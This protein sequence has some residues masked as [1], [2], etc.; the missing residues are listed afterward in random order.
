MRPVNGFGPDFLR[1][2]V[3][4]SIPSPQAAALSYRASFIAICL[5]LTLPMA[6]FGHAVL[7]AFF[8]LAALASALDLRYAETRAQFGAVLRSWTGRA[9]LA[10]F[11]W[12]V[13]ATL[14]SSYP[15]RSAEVAVRV[16]CFIGLTIPIVLHLAK[17]RAARELA[18]RVCA[19]GFA[20]VCVLAVA[21]FL[22]DTDLLILFR[23]FTHKV[24]HA[25]N[26]LKPFQSLIVVAV[27]VLAWI[28]L[29]HARLTRIAA[30]LG[31]LFGLV[32]T[33]GITGQSSR[34]AMAGIAGGA[35]TLLAIYLL[36]RLRKPIRVAVIAG[37]I[38]LGV[39]GMGVVVSVLPPPPVTEQDRTADPVPFLDFHREAIWGF[40]WHKA[41][42]KPVFGYGINTIDRSPG[43]QQEVLDLNQ[44]YVPS[45]PHN[46]LLEI[47]SETG[48]PGLVLALM[49]I[50]SALIPLSRWAR[51]KDRDIRAAAWAA[52]ASYGVF[53]ISALANFSIWSAWWQVTLL[54]AL[55][56]PIAMILE[57]QA[58]PRP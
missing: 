8:G 3:P 28:A 47:L 44:A 52:I 4:E 41:K 31:I 36:L 45:H 35:L 30:L 15:M 32:L 14:F 6:A 11:A 33:Q 13:I 10:L 5:G 20:V 24:I 27:P 49:A 7:G 58:N 19:F 22:F 54:A 25:N 46:W 16:A 23:P 53:W 50:A 29:R 1:K 2:A 57:R 43:A 38:G 40:V 34:S 26:M 56:F 55:S 48:F 37:L 51:H 39:L 18:E 12:W 9:W 21:I 42:E 17:N